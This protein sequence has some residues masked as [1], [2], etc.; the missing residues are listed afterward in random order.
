MNNV[1]RIYS[2]AKLNL[3]LQVIGRNQD[4]TH[5]LNTIFCKISLYDVL[6]LEVTTHSNE[7]VPL[8]PWANAW[9]YK[10]DLIYKA[11]KLLQ[12]VSGCSYG[13]KFTI[14]KNIPV[15]AGLG[16]GS[17]DAASI[18]QCLNVLW[19]L[20]YSREQLLQLACQLGDDVSSFLYS[21]ATL[22][23]NFQHTPIKLPNCYFLLIVPK[24]ALNT[25]EIFDQV[26]VH[27]N[28]FSAPVSSNILYLRQINDL[29]PYAVKASKNLA[30]II[31]KLHKINVD[32]KMTGSGSV[33]YIQFNT[34]ESAVNYAK[35]LAKILRGNYNF[36]KVVKRIDFSTIICTDV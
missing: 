36:L 35:N 7:I 10:N 32:V 21:G 29:L 1:Y 8:K 15:G 6:N 22:Y 28:I 12:D 5:L 33:L 26:R 24:K 34:R 11:A 14:Q 2:S 23:R 16:G 3:G 25:K 18:L 20:Y 30:F 4:G 9:D 13:V 17:S 27:Q 19:K 31:K